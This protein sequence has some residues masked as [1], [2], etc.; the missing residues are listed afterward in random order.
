MP[1]SRE[2]IITIRDISQE[3]VSFVFRRALSN[4]SSQKEKDH[5]ICYGP[6]HKTQFSIITVKEFYS[7]LCP[8]LGS[9][10][11][12]IYNSENV[13]DECAGCSDSDDCVEGYHS[14]KVDE[15]SFGI[16]NNSANFFVL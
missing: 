7:L 16:H 6:R 11:R 1:Y 15:E 13:G 4:S 12:D 5:Q 2:E 9:N 8:D 14:K 10:G 3:V